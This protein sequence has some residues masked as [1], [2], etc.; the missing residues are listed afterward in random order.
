MI[1]RPP[2]STLFPYTT[3]FRS[4]QLV[5]AFAKAR[6]HAW[7]ALGPGALEGRVG[8]TGRVGAGSVDDTMEVV[9]D[10]GQCV[11]RRFPLEVAELVYTAALHH[12]P[13]PHLADGA[14]QPGITVDDRQHRRPQSSRDEIVETALPR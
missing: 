11:L 14:P 5:A 10:R 1:R 12:R 8:G 7:A 6:H 9:A 2:R 4:E 3:L 13:R